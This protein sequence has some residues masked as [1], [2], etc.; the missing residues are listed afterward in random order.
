MHSR[1]TG[2]RNIKLCQL[3][4]KGVKVSSDVPSIPNVYDIERSTQPKI[5]CKKSE[6]K[7]ELHKV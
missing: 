2:K 6:S 1:P 5:S 3:S 4:V 7:H